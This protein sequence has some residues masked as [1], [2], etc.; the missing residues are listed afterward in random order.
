MYAFKLNLKLALILFFICFPDSSFALPSSQPRQWISAEYLHWWAQ[1]SPISVPL[2]TKNTNPSSF[3]IINQPA[4][5]II[6]GAGSRHNSFDFGGVNGARLTLGG[7]IDNNNRFGIEGSGLIFSQPKQTFSASSV[8]GRIPVLDVPFFS[9]QS[10]SE[11]VLVGNR[12]NTVTDSDDFKV[13]S[14]ELNGLFNVPNQLSIPLILTTGFRFMHFNEN[15]TLNDAIYQTPSLPPNSVLNVRDQFSTKNS[16]YGLQ[17]GARSTFSYYNL[18][19][20]VLAEI[21]FGI[22]HQQL[23]MS[24]QTNIDNKIILQPIGLFAEPTNS[25]TFRHNQFTFLP[26]LQMK[27]GYH[28]NK[29]IYPFIT[30]HIIYIHQIIRPGNEI[31]R[32]INLSQNPLIGGTGVLSGPATP[33]AQFRNT[34]FWMQGF[35]VG[36]EFTNWS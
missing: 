4:T 18:S 31:D 7:W 35:S 15:L 25:G 9:T 29:Y 32:N 26:E 13:S 23:N 8:N 3:A 11:T 34:S 19:L 20:E 21:A 30:Y 12:P 16:F 36:I 24:G 14:V 27:L 6:F 17:I 2:A 1:D 22:N 10:S 28:I 5:Q 33:S